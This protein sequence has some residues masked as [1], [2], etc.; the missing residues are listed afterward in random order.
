[1]ICFIS[2]DWR[3]AAVEAVDGNAQVV[4]KPAKVP[5]LLVDKVVAVILKILCLV[6]ERDFDA[7]WVLIEDLVRSFHKV[8]EVSVLF[9]LD[10]LFASNSLHR[11]SLYHP[12]QEPRDRPRGGSSGRT[13]SPSLPGSKR[14]E[15]K[16]VCL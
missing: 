8:L 1:M 3:E 7:S 4:E 9:K 5:D 14:G 6:M 15:M 2:L 10:G 13:F 11:V 16:A 12:V